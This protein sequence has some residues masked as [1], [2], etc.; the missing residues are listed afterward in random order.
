MAE[1]VRL[2]K[3]VVDALV[4]GPTEKIAFDR[5]L[6]GFGLKITPSGRK[7]FLFQYRFPPG[8]AGRTRRITIGEY[9]KAITP[10]QARAAALRLK[11]KVATNI[12]PFEEEREVHQAAARNVAEEKRAAERSIS[13]ICALYINRHVKPRNRSWAE[14]ERLLRQY[15]VPA[16]GDSQIDTV[17]RTHIVRLLDDVE[18]QRSRQTADAVLRVL[19]AMFNWHAVRDDDFV[20]PIVRGMNRSSAR[21]MARDRILNDQELKAV[22]TAMS[23]TPYPFGPLFKLLLLTA[24]RRDEVASMRWG[25][26]QGDLWIT[27]KERYKTGRENVIPLTPNVLSLLHELPRTGD[28][29]FTTTGATPVSGF[30]KAKRALDQKSGTADWRLHDLRRT[31]RSLMSRAG[32]SREVAERVLGHAVP[33]IVGVYDRHDYL[34]EK[35]AALLKLGSLVSEI[36][37]S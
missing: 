28:Y 14:Y 31:A 34:A 33:G 23:E 36:G 21:S 2:T 17:R 30:S 13:S 11:G 32:V 16:I 24:Q 5:D 9:G 20:N 19:R 26:L 3:R 15:V 35:R 10:D 8:R 37:Q 7:V 25:D 12:D 6:P 18:S 1:Q 27:P 29:V 4:A 22:W